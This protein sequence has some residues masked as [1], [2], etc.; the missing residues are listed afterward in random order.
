MAAF[1]FDELQLCV[2]V[3]CNRGF[4]VLGP[5]GALL[6]VLEQA[7]GVMHRVR[8]DEHGSYL[9][10]QLGHMYD[11]AWCESVLCWHII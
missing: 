3:V 10:V 1:T 2:A 4:I 6:H 5:D 8:V 7:Y 11:G 9:Y